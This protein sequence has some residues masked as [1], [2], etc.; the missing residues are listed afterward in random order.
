MHDDLGIP[1]R[2]TR[3]I[4]ISL[5]DRIATGIP[6][7]L[8]GPTGTEL[9][10]RGVSTELPLWSAHALFEAPDVLRTIHRDYLE[11]G[12]ELI[13]ANTFRTHERNLA[14]GGHAGEAASL[15]LEAVEIA[16]EV[17]GRRAWVAGSQA[18]LEDCYEPD[19]TPDAVALDSEHG[20]MAD[21]LAQA[22][23]DAILVETMPTIRE[24]LA[25][26]RAASSTGLP[27]LASFVCDSNGDLLSGESLRDAVAALLP[28]EPDALLVNC[29]PAP[30]L[31]R[32]LAALRDAA[33]D[34]T[35]GGYGNVGRPHP[36]HGWQA[37]DAVAP[38]AY[39]RYVDEW[40]VLGA[41]IV[42]GCCGTTPDHTRA[43]AACIAARNPTP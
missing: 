16:R 41:Q 42:G 33:P 36:V 29:A 21:Y 39:V 1:N 24:A 10:R 37:T 9:H 20:R 31:G 15:T 14:V 12:A 43:I 18:P 25:A 3:R 6:L 17:A 5:R 22:G 13:T 8:D 28:F 19:R 38:E 4:V 40:L 23:V 26:V 32:A 7:L 2:R 11:A 35:L 30:D 34:R 27:V